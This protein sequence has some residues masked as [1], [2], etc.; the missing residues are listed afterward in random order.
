MRADPVYAVSEIYSFAAAAENQFLNM[1]KEILDERLKGIIEEGLQTKSPSPNA[2]PERTDLQYD[3]SILEAH[4]DRIND[5]IA[6][7]KAAD[8]SVW[9]L[10]FAKPGPNEATTAARM[11]L[12][13]DFQYLHTQFVQL[14]QRCERAMEIVA[15]NASLLEAKRSNSQSDD[16]EQLTRLTTGVTLVYVPISFVCTFFGMNFSTFGQGDL[17]LWVFV[18]IS[19]PVLLI[20]LIF[21]KRKLNSD[22][23]KKISLKQ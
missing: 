9:F 6:F 5:I 20:S 8:D 16:L 14:V 21:L 12:L 7:L 17:P 3:R 11:S 19:V 1:M 10:P 23:K 18:A 4:S 22:S 15:H 13:Q 2:L